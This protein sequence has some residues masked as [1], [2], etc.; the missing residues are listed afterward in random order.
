VT[1]DSSGGGPRSLPLILARELAANLATPMFLIDGAGSLVYCN[2]AAEL[3]IGR[4]FGEL[5]VMPVNDF[6]DM[7]QV[8]E[9]DGEP[10]RRRDT[11]P[12][13]A[14]INREPAHRSMFI[15]GLDG[16]RRQVEVTAYPLFGRDD[17]M[18]GVL[19]VFWEATT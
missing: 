14:F 7:L 3:M 2:E 9:L 17:E 11:P 18:H 4:S 1:A 8:T 5:G 13:R 19:T 10:M 6:G 12:G 15:M 16:V